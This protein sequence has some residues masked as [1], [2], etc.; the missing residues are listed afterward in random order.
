MGVA[1]IGSV[2]SSSLPRERRQRRMP[3]AMLA[4]ARIVPGTPSR[5]LRSTPHALPYDAQNNKNGPAIAGSLFVAV[6]RC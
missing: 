2:R 3:A 5:I 1:G 6:G 4:T